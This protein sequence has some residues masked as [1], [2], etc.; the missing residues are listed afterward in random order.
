MKIAGYEQLE[1]LLSGKK[2]EYSQISFADSPA[3]NFIKANI[4][5]KN[6]ITLKSDGK[7][8]SLYL[9][10]NK[11]LKKTDAINQLKKKNI[12]AFTPIDSSSTYK[13]KL[14]KDKGITIIAQPWKT[15]KKFEN[16]IFFEKLLTTND[17]PKPKGW[18]LKS[19][20]DIELINKFPAVLQSPNSSGSRGTFFLNDKKEIKKTIESEKLKFPLLCREYING[21][22]FGIT[23]LIGKKEMILS[24]LRLQMYFPKKDGTSV[25]YGT[26]WI[27][28]SDL[29]KEV[30]K[31]IETNILKMGEV[32]I[33][34]KF[35]GIANFDFMI[36]DKEI[37]FIECN[38]RLVGP[39]PQISNTKELLHNLDFSAEFIAASTNKKLS[40]HK[41]FIPNT[42]FKGCTV[43]LDSL[44]S[45]LQNIRVKKLPKIGYYKIEK[46]K[47]E[48][49]SEKINDYNKAN[50][51]LLKHSLLPNEKINKNSLLGF[52]FTKEQMSKIHRNTYSMTKNGEK[53]LNSLQW[54]LGKT[55]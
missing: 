35:H 24:A 39:S 6:L 20:K 49:V 19:K 41:P 11:I 22:P 30:I 1:L 7:L 31:K 14:A 37:F 25:Y 46:N 40:L 29:P 53:T 47:L 3:Y 51:I 2:D 45:Q 4:P 33:S 10:E 32:L 42:K 26:Q 13:E 12:K 9:D 43:D 54:I 50:L 38:P 34:Q 44:K 5:T 16:K 28:K 52:A 27:K 36:K 21:L 15:Q 8:K 48:Y 23:L 18:I 55:Y 17:L